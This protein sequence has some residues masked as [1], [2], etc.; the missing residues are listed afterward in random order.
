MRQI[1]KDIEMTI[2]GSPRS[3]CCAGVNSGYL[4]I[5]PPVVSLRATRGKVLP[6][7]RR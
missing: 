3:V 2:D 6:E 7:T 4:F 5:T 1:T